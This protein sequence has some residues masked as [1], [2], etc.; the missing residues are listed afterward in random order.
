MNT[1]RLAW[2]YLWARPLGALLNLVLLAL[3]LG[4]ITFLLLVAHQLDSAFE[5]D[6]AGIDLVVGAKGSPLQLI[7]SGVLHLDVPT[8]NVPLAA[9]QALQRNPLVAQVIPMSLGD[10]VGG[11][12]VVGTSTDYVAHYQCRWRR[13]SCGRHP[14]RRCWAPMPH[15]AWVWGWVRSLRVAMVWVRAVQR[16][17]RTA[18]PWSAFLPLRARCWIGWC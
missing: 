13:D 15:S 18:T 1:L 8:G 5:R 17:V 3:G 7:L 10:S 2:R 12:R 14:C 6:L 11:F 16:T 4:S 9:V